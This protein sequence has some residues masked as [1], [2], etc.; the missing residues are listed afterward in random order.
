MLNKKVFFTI[1]FILILILAGLIFRTLLSDSSISDMSSGTFAITSGTS[2]PVINIPSS[3]SILYLDQFGIKG[4]GSVEGA[5]VQAALDYARDHSIS[6][7]VFPKDKVI[8]TTSKI[9]IHAGLNVIGNGCTIKLKDNAGIGSSVQIMSLMDNARCSG[10]KIDGN[11]HNNPGGG[12]PPG[13]A[14]IRLFSGSVFDGN[15]VFD[16]DTYT[17]FTYNADNVIISNN[18]IHGGRQYGIAT[19]G[20]DAEG[21]SH[22]IRVTGNTIYDQEQVGIKIRGTQDSIISYN[23]VTLPEIAGFDSE[24]ITLY[25]LDYGNSNIEISN[26]IVVGNLGRGSGTGTG[27]ESQS[28]ANTG[29]K[30]INNHVS[31]CDTGIHILFNN[32]IITGNTI[33]SC[34]RPLVNSGTG[35][36]VTNTIL[37][38]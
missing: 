7:V 34:T 25:S 22:N 5:K 15:E 6:T 24:G 27:I 1:I 31:K 10:I 19:G 18:I 35:N 36:A 9:I 3:S 33:S 17:V 28:S 14:G 11:R 12:S 23:T 32:A 37:T 26:N 4:D 30:I 16:V 20:G 13:A 29:I 21:I 38:T 8:I 2:T